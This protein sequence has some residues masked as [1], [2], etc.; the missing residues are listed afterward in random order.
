MSQLKLK[1]LLVLISLIMG[2]F[3]GRY[4]HSHSA[5]S[6]KEFS[7]TD[8]SS[9]YTNPLLTCGDIENLS[10]GE[11]ERIK[12]E[13]TALQSKKENSQVTHLSVYLRD[14]NN[15]P[16]LGLNEKEDF[17]PAS[18]LK[19]P[20]MFAAY[21]ADEDQPGFLN[22]V[23]KYE[24]PLF[25]NYQIF[26]PE[27]EIQPGQSYTLRELMRRSIIYSDNNATALLALQVGPQYSLKIFSDFGIEKPISDQDYTMKVRTYASFFRVLYNASYLS[28]K[29]SEEALSILAKVNFPN[30]IEAGL[31][32]GTT[33]SHKFGEREA[34][35]EDGNFQVHDCGIV[36]ANNPYLLCIMVQGKEVK[37]ILNL[38]ANVSKLV[39]QRIGE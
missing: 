9:V 13:I 11:M 38:I 15:G 8:P 31:P 22:R 34:R 36:Y 1:A 4:F 39:Y 21:K 3:L 5:Q 12:K 18:L 37:S 30:G 35:M 17:Y 19:V 24:A 6:F 33:F 10:V 27:E 25:N 20:L 32:K 29:N 7:E 26:P 28:K 2:F 16:W 23:V 14:L